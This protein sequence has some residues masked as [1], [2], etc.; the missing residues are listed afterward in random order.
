MDTVAWDGTY[1]IYQDGKLVEAGIWDNNPTVTPIVYNVDGLSNGVYNFTISAIGKFDSEVIDTAFVYVGEVNPPKFV[2]TPSNLTYN[3]G[4]VGNNLSWNATDEYPDTYFIYR[5]GV[6]IG[7]GS[8]DNANLITTSV[9]G[10]GLGIYN[11]TLL[12]IDQNNNKASHTVFVNVVDIIDPNLYQKP[13]NI[14]FEEGDTGNQLI[15]LA[16]DTHPGIMEIYK[17]ETLLFSSGWVA[18]SPISLGIDDLE[19]GYYNYTII[20]QDTSSNFVIDTSFVQVTDSAKPIIISIPDDLSYSFGTI[21]HALHWIA[22]DTNPTTF[23]VYRNHVEVQSGSWVTHETITINVDGLNEGIYNYTIVYVDAAGNQ[24]SDSANVTVKSGPI[25]ILIPP[26]YHYTNDT[27]GNEIIWIASDTSPSTYEL[28]RD[29][30]SIENGTWE[31]EIPIVFNIDGLTIG[32]YEYTLVLNDTD[33]NI[34]NSTVNVFVSDIPKFISSIA[35][36]PYSEGTFGNTIEWE[37]S[38]SFP[39]NYTIYLQDNP[40]EVGSWSN[41]VPISI[42]IDGYLKG[43]YNYTITVNDTAGNVVSKTVIVTVVDGTFPIVN[44]PTDF[45]Y[46]SGSLGNVINWTA[47]DTYPF[48]YTVY[49]NGSFYTEGM[50]SSGENISIDIDGLELGLHNFTIYISDASGNISNDSVQISVNDTIDPVIDYPTGFSYEYGSTSN[51]ITWNPSDLNSGSYVIFRNGTF[52]TSDSWSN[53]TPIII[54]VDAQVL[55]LHNFTLYLNDTSGNTVSHSVF[56]S[57]IDTLAPS[58]DKPLD[59]SYEYGSNSN[60]INWTGIDFNPYNYTVYLDAA[61]YSS[62]F[63]T[64]G[65]EIS[66]NVN[67]LNLG[68]YNFTIFLFDL[69]NNSISDSVLILVNDITT[70]SIDGPEDFGYELGDISNE[71]NWT[72][73]DLLADIFTVYLNGSFHSSNIWQSGNNIS[74]GIDGLDLGVHNFTI[75]VV[76]T[77]GNSDADTVLVTVVDTTDPLIDNPTDISYEL[78]SASNKITWDGSDLD[79]D[80]FT[81]YKDGEFYESRPWT[82]SQKIQI[83]IDGL[84]IG[85]YAF[86]IVISDGSGNTENDTVLV[87]VVDTTAPT[88][89]GMTTYYYPVGTTNNDI[90]WNAT[91]YNP[92]KYEIWRNTTRVDFGAWSEGTPIIINVDGLAVGVYNYSIYTNDTLGNLSSDL[93][94]VIVTDPEPPVLSQPTDIAFVEGTFN[95]T[96]EWTATDNNPDTYEI[97]QNGIPVDSDQWISGEIILYNLTGIAAGV[98]TFLIEISD[99]TN[100]IVTD[101]VIVTV[102]DLVKPTINPETGYEYEQGST[103][104][105]IEWIAFDSYANNYT[106]FNNVSFYESG[107]WTSGSPIIINID[108]LGVGAYNFT[109]IVYDESEN[110]VNDS[111]IITVVDTTIPTIDVTVNLTYEFGSENNLIKWNATDFNPD[112]YYYYINGSQSNSSV[113]I[114]GNEID[115]DIDGLGI[116]SYNYTIVVFDT[117][118]NMNNDTIFVTVQD[119]TRPSIDNPPNIQYEQGLTGN[120]LIWNGGDLDANNYS[121]YLDDVVNVSSTWNTSSPIM[122]NIDGLDTGVYNYTIYIWDVSNNSNSHSIIVTVVDTTKPLVSGPVTFEFSES[123]E[124]GVINWTISDWN[125]YN[126]SI[127]RDGVFVVNGLWNNS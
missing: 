19:Y 107:N 17:N 111:V 35:D 56:I 96:I 8:W 27:S 124:V 90:N 126:Y 33:A 40:I 10:L 118:G 112:I 47:T 93:V 26:N 99:T 59:Y 6:S 4:N 113:W 53:G 2:L 116:G 49:V 52:F 7:T 66:I 89:D 15:W 23:T 5:D 80:N 12:V 51:N 109:I 102:Y 24:N 73:T 81:V 103:P 122:L 25:F 97:Y 77:S 42:D 37:F 95:E 30:V 32:D 105:T 62:G 55:G 119:T 120:W 43:I 72:A 61:Y 100:N 11:I 69:V 76:D 34:S 91:D 110:S 22:Q 67:G 108:G 123:L 68:E 64:S 3:E 74:I 87:T 117:Y 60:F 38:D 84:S 28:F 127:F 46:E 125:P 88:I 106:V 18:H 71:I 83:N 36:S 16:N 13:G 94:Y 78:G 39:Q 115:I 29:G 21:G 75:I 85:T 41:G 121:I 86:E 50:W 44:E 57:I 9:D 70:P 31:D 82:S 114:S 79:P 48:N 63:W 1:T 92:D 54:N 14:T 101:T 98:H 20:I 65:T 58:I 104:N 45:I